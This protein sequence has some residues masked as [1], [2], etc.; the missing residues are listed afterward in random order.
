MYKLPLFPLNTVLFPGMPVRLHI[1][2]ERY[3]Q[4]MALCLQSRQ[5]FGVVL[6]REGVEANGPLAEPHMIGCTAHIIQVE[7]LPMG[8]MNVTAVGQERFKILAL[9]YDSAYLA[10][11]VE[12][13]PL[14]NQTPFALRRVGQK[15]RP[16]VER[17]LE[18]LTQAGNVEFDSSQLPADPVALAYLSAYLLQ[19]PPHHKQELLAMD[20][21]PAFVQSV[22]KLCRREVLLLDSILKRVTAEEMR[23]FS[24][25]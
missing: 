17:Y 5:P 4:M 13:C 7:P 23:P 14:D 25:N 22:T 8:R 9:N 3:K 18:M 10:A 6:I 1:F 12:S 21:A 16:W 20:D 24:V 11:V 2:E 19:V 15:L